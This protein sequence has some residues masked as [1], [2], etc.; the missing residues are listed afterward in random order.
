MDAVTVNPYLGFDSV[1]PFVDF[2]SKGCIILCRTSNTSASDIQ[3][4]DIDGEKFYQKVAKL[5]NDEW[6]YNKNCLLVVGATWPSQMTEI[7][8][9]VGNMPFLVPGVGAQGGD[10]RSMVEAGKTPDGMG[11]IIS[12][13]RAVLYASSGSDFAQAAR[14]VTLKLKKEINQYR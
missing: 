12:S 1:K 4:I 3:D 6:N 10:V 5:V 13:S 11:L 7:R 9:I 8:N 14:D 2:E